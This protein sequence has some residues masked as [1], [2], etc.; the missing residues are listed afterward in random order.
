MR[1]LL[2]PTESDKPISSVEIPD[3]PNN[4]QLQ[5]MRDLIGG[6]WLEPIHTNPLMDTIDRAQSPHLYRIVMLVD[7]DGAGRLPPNVRAS[8][9]YAPGKA[10]IY[11]PAIILGEYRDQ[12]EGDD[13]LTL[14][15][16]YTAEYLTAHIITRMGK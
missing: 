5:F 3:T 12:L 7:E 16:Y 15:D 10:Y 14:P 11:G 9:L 8:Q 4:I 6:G 2:I 13:F 1:G